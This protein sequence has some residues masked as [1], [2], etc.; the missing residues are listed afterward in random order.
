MVQLETAAE[1]GCCILGH[2]LVH[3]LHTSV[4]DNIQP[5]SEMGHLGNGSVGDV[6][7]LT[8]LN[9]F[10]PKMGQMEHVPN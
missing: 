9:H 2:R 1:E 7:H 4:S 5:A 6:F 3:M 8:Y 10:L